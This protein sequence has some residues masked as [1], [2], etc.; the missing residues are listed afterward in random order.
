MDAEPSMWILAGEVMTTQ[1]GQVKP[2]DDLWPQ[3]AELFPRAVR[4]LEDPNDEDDY[5]FFA[6]SDE[7]GRF[8]GGSVVAI[9][10]L[11][12]GP[13]SETTIGFLE[14]IEVLEP[15]RRK[16]AGAALLRATLDHAWSR[17]CEN[18]RG[19]VAYDNPAGIALYR[20]MGLGFVPDEV[21][22]VEPPEKQYTI[23]AINP[24]RVS[25]GY[26]R[27]HDARDDNEDAAAQP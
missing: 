26:A 5:D 22:G 25:A 12:F 11:R 1:V 2:G 8:L 24:D 21:P 16:G 3:V 15:H 4:W 20:S 14:D 18:V 9:G 23:V 7:A 27:E 19:Q 17:G 6:A 13:L 10:R